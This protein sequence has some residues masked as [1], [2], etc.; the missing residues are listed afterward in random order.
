MHRKL[1][2]ARRTALGLLAGLP[3]NLPARRASATASMEV[4]QAEVLRAAEFA[5]AQG[6][7]HR[8]GE[9]TRPLVL[10]NLWAA[11]CAGCLAEMPT[12][13]A[14][15]S[16][17]IPDAIDVVLLSHDMNW[18]VDVAYVREA[19]LPFRHWRLSA[20]VPA[21]V[22]ATS[23]RMERDRFALPQSLVFAGRNRSLV[24]YFEGSQDWASAGQ[25]SRARAWLVAA[26]QDAAV[27]PK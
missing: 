15:T 4:R 11:W 14:L 12:I 26:G 8:L 10:V 21:A 20:Q 3:V 7:I 5:D 24:S 22:V 6:S 25:I 19:K 1:P 17:L 18:Q 16:R 2:L 27:S 13:R 9:L 23:F